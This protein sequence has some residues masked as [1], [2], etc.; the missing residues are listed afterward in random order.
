MRSEQPQ[1]TLTDADRQHDIDVWRQ[2]AWT[3]EAGSE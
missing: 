1:L 3:R 2:E